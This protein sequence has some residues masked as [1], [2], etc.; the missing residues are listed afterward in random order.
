MVLDL[1]IRKKQLV[2]IVTLN[3]D[4][5]FDIEVT[6]SITHKMI[7]TVTSN[8]IED[9]SVIADHVSLE[10][11]QLTIEGF[12][13]EVPLSTVQSETTAL[14][15]GISSQFL[16]GALAGSV[17][18]A[19]GQSSNRIL[20]AFLILEEL[21]NNKLPFSIQTGLKLY[22][23][24][25]VTDLTIPRN[26]ETSLRFTMNMQ[27][28]TFATSEIVKVPETTVAQDVAHTASSTQNE[29]KKTVKEISTNTQTKGQT[30]LRKM[31]GLLEGVF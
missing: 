28:L 26:V 27:Q 22:E 6:P 21:Y 30:I 7:S 12:I 4:T 1:L 10:N 2:Q 18:A 17:V 3:S 24:M 15:T 9:G 11:R 20:D 25:I 13:S 14:A 29:G 5:P 8:P 19:F 23:N 16:P 31:Q